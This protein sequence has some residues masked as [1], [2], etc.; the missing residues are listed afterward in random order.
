MNLLKKDEDIIFLNETSESI[1]K[2]NKTSSVSSSNPNKILSL[3]AIDTLSI[4]LG[5][6]DSVFGNSNKVEAPALT[7][8]AILLV[9][10]SGCGC[11]TLVVEAI[12]AYYPNL[13]FVDFSIGTS[14]IARAKLSN[15]LSYIDWIKQEWCRILL[16]ATSYKKC[17][18]MLSDLHA[19]TPRILM[20]DYNIPETEEIIEVILS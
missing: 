18:L 10:E 7:N 3:Y 9:G 20:N 11:S 16:L 17:V 13:Q 6:I 2:S 5:S 4:L 12:S 1:Y 14:L 19:L 15:R 8:S